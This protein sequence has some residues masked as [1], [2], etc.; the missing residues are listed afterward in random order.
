MKNIYTKILTLT[1][2]L[3]FVCFE[4]RASLELEVEKV[5]PVVKSFMLMVEDVHKKK[6]PPVAYDLLL[7]VNAS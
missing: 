4:S 5:P 7:S 1:L 3:F 6:K 2:G